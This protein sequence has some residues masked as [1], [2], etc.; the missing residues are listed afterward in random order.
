MAGRLLFERR[1]NLPA[2]IGRERAA[3][4]KDAADDASLRR[5]GTMP[6]DLGEPPRRACQRGAELRHRAEQ[7]LRIGMARAGEQL[8]D[9]RLLDLAAGIHHDHALGD[10]GDHAEIVGDQ[11]DRRADVGA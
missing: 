8:G 1:R 3:P 2:E 9:R 4:G 5:L 10:L 11:H 6:G 7:A